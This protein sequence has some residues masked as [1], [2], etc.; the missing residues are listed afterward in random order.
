[1]IKIELNPNDL[2]AT[3]HVLREA[4]SDLMGA[5]RWDGTHLH[6]PQAIAEYL[7]GITP[8]DRH[9]R[10]ARAVANARLN[11]E[12]EARLAAPFVHPLATIDQRPSDIANW[13]G[14]AQLA[15][16]LIAAGQGAVPMSLRDAHNTTISLPAT[17]V[18]ALLT[19]MALNRAAIMEASW[20]AKSAVNEAE[21]KEDVDAV[22][23]SAWATLTPAA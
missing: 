16:Q 9:V 13:L 12:R 1:M 17:D 14:A 3:I 23:W 21:T 6:V 20:T 11:A 4:F 2:D 10:H 19:A 7:D 8:A 15:N 22:V 18:A 5:I